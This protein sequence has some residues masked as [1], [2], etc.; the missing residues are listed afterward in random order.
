M[1]LRNALLAAT[2]LVA[3]PLAVHAQAIDGLYIGAGAGGNLLQTETVHSNPGGPLNTG[4]GSNLR[5]NAGPVVVGSVGYG[6]AGLFPGS[7]LSGFRVELQGAGYENK[8]N[9]IKNGGFSTQT[10][11]AFVHLTS[12]GGDEYKYGA[13]LNVLYDVPLSQFGIDS[14]VFPYL[15]A[16]V[17]YVHNQFNNVHITGVNQLNVVQQFQRITGQNDNLGVQGIAGLSFPVYDF[18]PGLAFTAEYRFMGEIGG[19]DYRGQYYHNSAGAAGTETRTKFGS[20]DFN[21]SILLGI[22]YAF[23]TPQPVVVAPPPAAAECAGRPHLPGVL[24]LGP[25]GPDRPRPA[26]RRR[27]GAG[28]H[29]R[30]VH[31]DRSAGQRRPLRHP[32]LQPAPVA[33]PR[34]DRRRRTGAQRCAPHGHRHPGVRRHAPARADRGRRA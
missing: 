29:P 34:P 28:Q 18:V 25:C 10:G 4:H 24:R 14:P 6:F 33:A 15:G 27:G 19:R 3:A 2:V 17:G 32:G 7:I 13:F 21:H 30:A 20:D 31:A 1:K 9:R 11:T 16:G 22:R 5:F 23:N 12:E 26:D 8:L